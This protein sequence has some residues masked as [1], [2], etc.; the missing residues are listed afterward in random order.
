MKT[1]TKISH[2]PSKAA[3]R[4]KAILLG[5]LI[6]AAASPLSQATVAPLAAGDTVIGIPSNPFLGGTIIAAMTHT[7]TT[8]SPNGIAGNFDEWVVQESGGTLDFYYQF[9]ITSSHTP[10]TEGLSG[11]QAITFDGFT[12]GAFAL[13]STAGTPFVSGSNLGVS[14]FLAYTNLS[15]VGTPALV[16][17][18]GVTLKYN[19]FPTSLLLSKPNSAI[20]A[21][22]TTATHYGAGNITFQDGGFSAQYSTF[23]P[24]PEP[25]VALFGFA[26]LVVVGIAKSRRA[27]G[28][29]MHE[30]AV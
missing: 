29:T 14:P 16:S 7:Y 15:Q 5:A 22:T 24:V 23:V 12:A 20:L 4:H 28:S 6:L 10:A 30:S 2:G 27:S 9:N 18:D 17:N 11:I 26:L 3:P 19:F 8:P 1:T 25:T 21:I 13:D